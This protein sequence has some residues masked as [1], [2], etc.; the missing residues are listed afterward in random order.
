MLL[1]EEC[2]DVS[3]AGFVDPCALPGVDVIF[4][5]TQR[6]RVTSDLFS[7][8]AF[9]HP[10]ATLMLTMKAPLLSATLFLF[11]TLL[12][13][14]ASVEMGQTSEQVL[15]ALGKPIGTIELREKTLLLYPQGEITLKQGKVTEIDLMSE[16]QFEA[17]QE[18]LRAEREEWLV[19]QE[20]RRAAHK[21]EGESLKASKLKSS[22][23]AALPAK[24]KVDYWRSFQTR[25]PSVDAS[26]QIAS[27]LEGY[28]T[29]LEE[30]RSQQRI[31]ELEARVA[32]A[33]KE[34]AT[35]RLETEKLR[36]ETERTERS[37]NYYGL[38]YYTDPVINTSRYYYR[39]PTIT[40][41]TDGNG[42]TTTHH[43][44]GPHDKRKPRYKQSE[45]VAERATRILN[46]A[47]NK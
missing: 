24:D 19:D 7:A 14:A 30:L 16:E 11:T 9:L 26:E 22:A 31:A 4:K 33:E 28:E 20:R 40:I 35:A 41:Y 2:T 23:F 29:E 3:L 12:A 1:L 6:R 21:E 44:N 34:T 45:S 5:P 15:A 8:F 39:P 42:N 25:Y 10:M 32:Q 37:R 43:S 27:A 13:P 46:E 17:D 36:E 38:R 47:T 18:R